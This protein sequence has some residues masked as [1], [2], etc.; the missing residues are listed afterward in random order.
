MNWD[1]DDSHTLWLFFPCLWNY[2]HVGWECSSAVAH[3]PHTYKA[4][5]SIPNTA[6]KQ[7]NKALHQSVLCVSICMAQSSRSLNNHTWK[8][9]D[10][11]GGAH[12]WS[13]HSGGRG[14]QEG[15]FSKFQGFQGYTVRPFLKTN[16]WDWMKLTE[17]ITKQSSPEL[18]FIHC[19]LRFSTTCFS[20]CN[21]NHK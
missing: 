11:T 10:W 9:W 21:I 7:T 16:N 8:D 20:C 17:S 14:R 1:S 15:L 2:T 18:D 19:S 4:L 3:L 5:A 6:N 12:L 13:W